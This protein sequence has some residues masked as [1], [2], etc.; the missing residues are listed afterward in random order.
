[1]ATKKLQCERTSRMNSSY[2]IINGL[3]S[4]LENEVKW[5]T[6]NKFPLMV[7]ID[8]VES[9]PYLQ[10]R[11]V[12]W[13]ELVHC[14]CRNNKLWRCSALLLGLV[15]WSLGRDALWL[16]LQ[17]GGSGVV[18]ADCAIAVTNAYVSATYSF[19]SFPQLILPFLSY[20][21]KI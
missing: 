14:S 6:K 13:I 11:D 10:Q 18:R 20:F 15:L 21:T 17:F 19:P 1:M 5:K 3:A 8:F 12:N 7:A 2:F 4:D 16:F 9:R